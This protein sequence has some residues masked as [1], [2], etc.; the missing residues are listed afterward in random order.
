MEIATMKQTPV[1]ALK[2]VGAEREK[3]LQKRNIYNIYDLL[4]SF[5]REYENRGNVKTISQLEDGETVAVHAMIASKASQRRIRANLSVCKFAI[6]DTTGNATIVFYNQPFL[7]NTFHFGQW[8][9]FYGKVTRNFG[10]IELQTPTYDKEK[11]GVVPVYHLTQGLSQNILRKTIQAA[12]DMVGEIPDYLPTWLREEYGLCSLQ[13]ALYMVHFPQDEAQAAKARKRL[14]FDEL[15]L[16]QL[17]LFRVRNC[18]KQEVKGFTFAKVPE[19]QT[20]IDGLPFALTQAQK[21][22]LHEIEEDMESPRVM[23]RLVQGDVGSGKTIVAL[24]A[25][26][27]AVKSGYQ[28]AYMA[29]TEILAEQHFRNINGFLEATGVRTAILKGSQNRAQREEALQQIADGQVDIV[30]GTHALIQES[31]KFS[32]LGLVITD[33]QHRFGVRQREILAGKAEGVPDVLVMTATPIPRTLGLILYGDLD[34]SVIDTMP[35]GRLPIKTYV[36]GES[37]RER[38]S[39]FILKQVEEDHQ[40]YIVC[41]AIEEKEEQEGLPEMD[42]L[43]KAEEYYKEVTDCANGV[44]R[45]V[46]VGLIHGKMKRS[47]QE[48]TMSRFASGEIKILIATTVIEVGVDVPNATLM[49]VENAERFGLAQLHQLRG[50]VGRGKDQSFC[51]LFCQSRS[52]VSRERMQVMASTTDGFVIAQKDLEIRGPGEFFGTRQHGLPTLRIAN[53]YQDTDILRLA[54]K[55]AGLFMEGVFRLS[56]AEEKAV[57]ALTMDI[58]L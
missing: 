11:Q 48:A 32:K 52:D 2:G 15:F 9:Y 44:F 45:H 35:Q 33:E 49:V 51:V 19:L 6:K 10:V 46:E 23:N 24:L 13:E 25:M 55:A 21:S 8:Y 30:I 4:Y 53:L 1:T 50:R 47:E 56:D 31:V 3:L 37:M 27:K 41:P 58:I 57:N 16:L 54:Q 38:I 20:F 28:A 29:P 36:V 26:L 5:P 39:K 22:V 42:A 12:F 43:K 18:M 34:I 7:K 17:S 14:V 40:V